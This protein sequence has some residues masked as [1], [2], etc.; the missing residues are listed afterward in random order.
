MVH[1]LRILALFEDIRDP[2]LDFAPRY[3]Y[4]T[5]VYGKELK[6]IRDIYEDEKHDPQLPR[7]STPIVGK[8]AWAR[9]LLQRIREPIEEIQRRCPEA[10]KV[11]N[12]RFSYQLYL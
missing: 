4:I 1:L 12:F 9:N 6:K 10:L 2:G 3:D 11:D 8:I 5:G 7:N